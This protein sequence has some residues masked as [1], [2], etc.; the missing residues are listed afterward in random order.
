MRNWL[1][2]VALLTCTVCSG[3]VEVVKKKSLVGVTK[4]EIVG[5]RIFVGNDSNPSVSDVAVIKVDKS[6]K[7]SQ[8]KI[9]R[10]GA[11]V[12]P[13]KLA[14]GDLILVGKGSY[15]IDATLFDPDK[16]IWNEEFSVTLGGDAP[17]PTPPDD[18]VTPPKPV[19]DGE[20]GLAALA[21]NHPADENNA[22]IIGNAYR[23][24]GNSLFG[25]G[26]LRSVE[27]SVAD[28]N[29]VFAAKVCPSQEV[30]QQWAA[31]K[32]KIDNRIREIQQGKQL[33]REDWYK[34]L[35]EIADGMAK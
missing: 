31:W 22:T 30:C 25:I 17:K 20:F 8:L 19:P 9:K 26:N 15:L 18:D 6:Y 34:L 32:A 14:S 10:D 4:P 28:I 13:E 21:A 3:Q 5:D 27:Q 7:F 33:S 2:L 29:R 1:I 16:G 23:A 24:A 12:E 35:M 11:R